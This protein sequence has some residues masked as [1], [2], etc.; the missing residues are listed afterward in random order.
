MKDNKLNEL[1]EIAIGASIEAGEQILEVY[2]KDFNVELKGD[3]SP[4]TLADKKSH[5][6]IF[7]RLSMTDYPVLSEEGKS[8][9]YNK[10]KTWTTFWMVDPLDGTKEF[11]KRNGE[12]TVNIA[13]IEDNKPILGVIYIPVQQ[14][15]YFASVYLG[16]YKVNLVSTSNHNSISEFIEVMIIF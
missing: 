13:L 8:I 4:L 5:D 6:L 16:S 11:I 2:N 1:L 3:N 9:P 12:F 10:R 15:L 14:K 7:A